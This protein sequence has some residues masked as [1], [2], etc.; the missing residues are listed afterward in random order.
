MNS[1]SIKILLSVFLIAMLFISNAFSE[2][3]GNRKSNTLNKPTG[4]PVRAYMN[5]NLI[6]TVI[7]NTGISDIDVAQ[8]NSGLVYPKGS[9]KTAVFQSGLVWAAMLHDDTEFDP[10]VG[11][12]TYEEGLQGGWIDAAGNVIP[13]S[14]PRARIFRVRP[15]VYSG[16][17]TV[18]LSP[19][20]ADE[21]RAEADVR[22]QYETDWT[23]WPADLGAPYF[24]GNGNGIYD[25]I[26][27]PVDSL[28]DIPGVPG[29]NQTLWYVANDQES[30]LTQNLYGTQ[31]MGMEMQAT[32]WGYA[33][34]GALGNMFFRRYILINK[35]DVLGDPRTF[36]SM[37]VSM[38]S[39]VDLGNSSDDFAGSDTTL[40]L[41]YCYNGIAN[42]PTYNPLPPP[43]VGFDFFQGPLVDGVAGEDLNKNGVDDADDFGI[44]K[45]SNVGPGKINLP[46]TAAYY[47]TRGDATVTDPVLGSPDEGAVRFYR[48]MQGRIGLTGAPFINPATGLPTPFVLSGDP[49]TGEGWVDGMLQSPGDRRIGEASGPFTMAPGDTQEVVVAEICAGAVPG[50]DRLS[51]VSLLKFYDQIAQ[52]AYD[53]FFDLPVP[54]PAPAVTIAELDEEIILDWSKD[55][56]KVLATESSDSKGYKFQGYNVYQLPNASASISE[57]ARI[58]T[59]DIID[60]VGKISD[61]VFDPTTGSVVVLPVQFGNDTGLRRFISIKQ[62]ALTQQPL[63]NGIRYYFAVTAYNYNDDPQAVPN[64]L[65]NPIQIFTIVPHSNNP[66][67]SYGGDNGSEVQITHNGTADGG[68][69]VTIVDPTATT[70]HE[71][72]LSFKSQSQ[73]RNANGDWIPA[74]TTLRKVMDP[75]DPDTLTGSSIDITSIF[76]PTPGMPIEIHFY[77]NYVSPDFNWAD[78][79][80]LDFPAGMTIVDFPSFEAGGGTIDPLITGDPTTGYHIEMG[81]VSGVLSGDGIFH[82]GEEWI[83][84]VEP[85]TP[86]QSFDWIIW[87][88]GYSGGAVNAEGT[89]TIDAIGFAERIANLWD[90]TD[91]ATEQVVLADQSMYAGNDLYPR[92]DDIQT[93]LGLDASPIADGFQI[94]VDVGFT[95]PVTI[96]ANNPPTLNGE[97]V[98]TYSGSD[99]W[100]DSDNYNVCDFQRFGY[101]PATVL[102]TLG[103]SGGGYVSE[104]VGSADINLLQ[105][106]IEFR[107]TGIVADTVLASGDTL[108]ITQSGGSLITL[109]GA[110]LYSIADHPLNPSPG[111]ENPFT[112][113]VPFEIWNLDTGEQINAIMWDRSGNPTVNGGKVWNDAN[114]EYLW[115][116][117]NPYAEVALDPIGPEID[118]FGTWN[119]VFYRSL[120][121]V[122]DVVR[123]NYDNPIQIGTDT[124]TFSTVAPGYSTDLALDQVDEINVSQIHTMVLIQ[125][126]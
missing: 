95:A 56:S 115:L 59:Y 88:D 108:T 64:N 102:G 58:A 104:D 50:V 107:F 118:E 87:D 74:G 112:I 69:I 96:S 93:E 117:S 7:K 98:F 124:Y 38:W 66:G 78:G 55:N 39:D 60:G 116:V 75:N 106:D 77:Y 67:V 105:Q 63:I 29:S 12:S 89:T 79:I 54:P 6:S 27:D 114:R 5:I 8:A 32:F 48:F 110:S 37:Y 25:P 70:G 36:D 100:W 19:E 30:G 65:E 17:P 61:L 99:V 52:V 68:P 34:T 10:H 122:G 40:S 81:D 31:P 51:A 125:K 121:T 4:T 33:Q 72:E 94:N 101:S 2:D 53:N 47:F 42:D 21:G 123:L 82:G 109:F 80:E 44:F 35:T 111:S 85:F 103:P 22:A 9:G 41:M 62:D 46:M 92:R 15:D 3:D 14:D 90:V 13:P 76:P 23:E 73:V 20:A 84:F 126:S 24:D 18:D 113:R 26:P 86:P 119:V 71:Y 120:H 16:G 11:G 43:A 91:L 57:G 97:E 49:I 28:R 45:G 83:V 1:K